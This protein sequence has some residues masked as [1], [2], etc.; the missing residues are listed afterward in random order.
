[1]QTFRLYPEKELLPVESVPVLSRNPSCRKCFLP[2]NGQNK[3]VCISPKGQAGGVLV[4]GDA[5]GGAEDASGEPFQGGSGGYVRSL[6]SAY[7]QGPVVWDYAVRC[8]PKHTPLTS[9]IIAACRGYLRKSVELVVPTKI[10]LLGSAAIEAFTG[11][12]LPPFSVWRGYTQLASGATVY[13]LPSPVVSSKNPFIKKMFEENLIWALTKQPKFA[14]PRDEVVRIVET[15]QDAEEACVALR[16]A[17]WFAFD[18]EVSGVMYTADFSLLSLSASAYGV[19]E[20]PGC[21]SY[22]WPKHVLYGEV[23]EPLKALL[24]DPTVKKVGQ[25][26]KFDIQAIRASLGVWVEGLYG[27]T[28]LWTKLFDADARASLDILSEKV[29]MGGHKGEMHEALVGVEK[30]LKASAKKKKVA[31][32]GFSLGGESDVASTSVGD[33][34]SVKKWSYAYVNPVLLWRYNARDS[35][36][37]AR[38]GVLLEEELNKPEGEPHKRIWEQISGPAS[39]A[40]SRIEDWGVLVDQ[41]A[42]RMFSS[43]LEGKIKA[44]AFMLASQGLTDPG[45]NPQT[46]KYI[47]ETLKLPILKQTEKGSPSVDKEALE[48]LA[49]SYPHVGSLLEWRRLTKLKSTYADPLP[50]YV[51]ADGRI[52]PHFKMDGTRTGRLSCKNPNTQNLPRA[53]G[54]QEAKIIRSCYVAAPGCVFLEF[55]FS[56]LE[57]R[58][59][60]MLSGDVAM[61]QIFLDGVDFHM[62]VAQMISQI[63]WGISPEQVDEEKRS[64][65]KTTL[66]GTLYGMSAAGFAAQLGISKQ[67]AAEIQDAILGQFKQ[68]KAWIAKQLAYAKK[69]GETWTWWAGERGRRRPLWQIVDADSQARGSAERS[70]YNTT[71]Q[72]TGSDFCMASIVAVVEWL[73]SDLVPAK[74]VLTVHDSILLEVKK[75][76][77]SEVFW[78]VR[79][80]MTSHQVDN[81]IPL[82]VDAK[83]GETWGSMSAYRE[84]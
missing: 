36:A 38:L 42:I 33:G 53:K 4:I 3:T 17:P 35:L 65:A 44:L 54:S 5:P 63:A 30:S 23:G 59:A 84:K 49:Q 61:K 47:Y 60:A 29:G 69:H 21:V 39:L 1:M 76:S 81:G 12:A 11:R 45:S 83:I 26:V 50:G 43:F 18:V 9:K 27:D 7:W 74:V 80:L 56:Q 19:G 31:Q 82:V 25:N 58:I 62:R 67:S 13:F 41:G 48:D 28:R 68:L 15:V 40:L 46:A 34:V 71:V 55:D 57:L 75:E 20:R 10:L 16:R 79:R 2:T 6:V 64:I 77:L 37:T 73:V 52:H 32:G 22:C 24:T 14:A 51:R 66:F 72:G 8:W 78:Q 70:S